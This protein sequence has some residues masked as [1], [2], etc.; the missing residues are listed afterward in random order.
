MTGH[1]L[2]CYALL[3]SSLILSVQVPIS[4]QAAD[5][6]DTAPVLIAAAVPAKSSLVIDFN[7]FYG[8]KYKEIEKEF[9]KFSPQEKPS[10]DSLKVWTQ[11][12]MPDSVN[13]SR[14]EGP[15]S[16]DI[17]ASNRKF[18]IPDQPAGLHGYSLRFTFISGKG[19]SYAYMYFRPTID[20][21]KNALLDLDA[22][23]VKGMTRGKDITVQLSQK[24]MECNPF[25]L[26]GQCRAHYE[27]KE[28]PVDS[29]GRFR[30]KVPFEPPQTLEIHYKTPN[31]HTLN[32]YKQ[33][34]AVTPE[35]SDTVV[36]DMTD[37]A[38]G[39]DGSCGHMH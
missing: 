6:T 37:V 25:L 23:D 3:A 7:T 16:K 31:K 1:T 38:D 28:Y 27:E 17:Y 15:W 9:T 11:D 35:S 24:L 12:A 19:P 5:S 26:S 30:I 36:V 14:D 32:I 34:F 2:F 20:P 22:Q 29:Q 18:I 21:G 33:N 39:C 10:P 8:D 4:A 13:Y